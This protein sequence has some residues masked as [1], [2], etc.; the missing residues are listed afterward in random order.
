[1]THNE[2]PNTPPNTKA[3]KKVRSKNVSHRHTIN[4]FII[5]S[6]DH[7][8]A[9]YRSSSKPRNLTVSAIT[10]DATQQI[11]QVLCVVAFTLST[12]SNN[13]ASSFPKTSPIIRLP[14][15]SRRKVNKPSLLF[16]TNSRTQA[17]FEC[18]YHRPPPR[19]RSLVYLCHTYDEEVNL[20]LCESSMPSFSTAS[21]IATATNNSKCGA[22]GNNAG[23][24]GHELPADCINTSF[25][26]HTE[27][28][29]VLVC[30]AAQLFRLRHSSL[31]PTKTV[32]IPVVPFSLRNRED[33]VPTGVM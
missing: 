21:V 33:P 16:P 32:L 14:L 24:A 12:S 28:R 6:G 20:S 9:V 7:N 25:W 22:T 27:T 4:P 13:V 26:A 3:A 2:I 31:H 5:S 8:I 1:M 29:L 18:S 10:S 30:S 17:R 23:E 11:L 15:S 19:P